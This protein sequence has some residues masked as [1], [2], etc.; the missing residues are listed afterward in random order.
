MPSSAILKNN[1]RTVCFVS[2]SGE[3]QSTIAIARFIQ[4]KE[5]LAKDN[6]QSKTVDL[7]R[8]LK[9]PANAP[10]LVVAG[11][12]RNYVQPEVDA[13]KK[14]VED[15]GRAFFHARSSSQDRT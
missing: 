10:R 1:T 9:S 14:Y 8:S 7:L 15:G 5:L 13:I 4:F 11:P 6:Y 2:G 3:H 12:T